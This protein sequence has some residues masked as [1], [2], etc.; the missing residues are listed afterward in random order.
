M[1]KV[2]SQV[3]NILEKMDCAEIISKKIISHAS[4]I[5]IRRH[6]ILGAEC[7]QR[8]QREIEAIDLNILSEDSTD[9]ERGV[10]SILKSRRR[11][12]MGKI[13]VTV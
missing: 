10:R 5:F 6:I 9:E 12:R 11:L 7:I 8:I 2:L 13:E 1:T 3:L 4:Y